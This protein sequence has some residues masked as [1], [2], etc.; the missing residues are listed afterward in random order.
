[1]NADEI[2]NYVAGLQ[3]HIVDLDKML[4]DMHA[5][6]RVE[7]GKVVVL[8]RENRNLKE[9]GSGNVATIMK[10][11]AELD[12]CRASMRHAVCNEA[13]AARRANLHLAALDSELGRSRD[14]RQTIDRLTKELEDCQ[15]SLRHAVEKEL[16]RHTFTIED[17]KGWLLWRAAAVAEVEGRTRA[18][19]VAVVLAD[20]LTSKDSGIVNWKA[21]PK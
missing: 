9:N 19:E 20:I 17:I 4:D 13:T 6:W 21:T 5:K 15:R 11:T 7:C 1:M 14:L 16:S 3:V 10:L 12:D 2:H 18:V 8:E